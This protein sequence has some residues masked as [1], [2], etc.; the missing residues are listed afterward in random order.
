MP[1]TFFPTQIGYTPTGVGTTLNT[2]T[3]YLGRVVSGT[4]FDGPGFGAGG[5]PDYLQRVW[6]SLT[7]RATD[8]T[9]TQLGSLS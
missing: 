3:L 8:G 7:K 4:Y 5:R 1:N 9:L 2:S 6:I